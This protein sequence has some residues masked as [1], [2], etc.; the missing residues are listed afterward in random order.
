MVTLRTMGR[1]VDSFHGL[2]ANRKFKTTIIACLSTCMYWNME[3]N[4]FFYV[5]QQK[6]IYNINA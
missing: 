2:L 4:S 6:A 5:Q 3:G 1:H